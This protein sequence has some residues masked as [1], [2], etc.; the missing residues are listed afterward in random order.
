MAQPSLTGSTLPSESELAT[1]ARAAAHLL[2]ERLT[3]SAGSRTVRTR[4]GVGFQ[5][6]DHREYV[7]GDEVRHID[8]RQTA[9]RRTPIVRRYESEA[10]GEWTILVDASSSMVA[11]G[12]KWHAALQ[13]AAAMSY[14]LLQ[15]GH[16]VALVAFGERVLAQCPR[17]RG[18]QHYAAIA[19]ALSALRPSARSERSRLGTCLPLL[20]GAPSAFVVSDFLADDEMSRDL[21]AM[22]ERCTAVHAVQVSDD[23][24]IDLA[25]VAGDVELVDVET[26]IRMPA[27]LVA[28]TR[29]LASAERAAMTSR[30]RRFC[31]SSGIAFTDWRVADSWQ[32]ALVR[33]LVEARSVC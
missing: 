28:R 22:L 5:H 10:V 7:P 13:A 33:H 20:R 8:W 3:R 11:A 1:F 30:L 27:S 4:A 25:G 19:R 26:G 29:S 17:G 2:S 18:E 12:V 14:A 23:A 31:A 9:R 16:R 32:A 24:E 21:G 6:L 15:L